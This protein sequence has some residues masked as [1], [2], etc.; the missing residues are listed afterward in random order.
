MKCGTSAV[1]LA[2]QGGHLEVLQYLVM[3]AG[4]STRIM[5]YDGMT[6]LHAAAQHGHLDVI[7][8]LV[9]IVQP[10]MA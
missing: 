10:H 7:R 1:Y 6:C 9:G 5:A 3:E 4:A 2:A 8:W